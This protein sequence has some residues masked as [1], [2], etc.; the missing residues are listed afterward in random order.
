[1][2]LLAALLEAVEPLATRPVAGFLTSIDSCIASEKSGERVD[3][4]TYIES[5]RSRKTTDN[6]ERN[7]GMRAYVRPDAAPI[8]VSLHSDFGAGCDVEADRLAAGG[9]GAML[10]PLET[11]FG[12]PAQ[13]MSGLPNGTILRLA[14]PHHSILYES[15]VREKAPFSFTVTYVNRYPRT[16]IK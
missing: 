3:E 4:S 11:K 1:M 13:T 16:E 8:Y 12:A 5:G 15:G 2:I 14:P 10:V 7:S 6:E 9:Q